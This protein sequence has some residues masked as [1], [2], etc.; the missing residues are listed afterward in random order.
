[1]DARARVLAAEAAAAL[2]DLAG[3]FDLVFLDPPYAD[4][5]E[6]TAPALVPGAAERLA[7]DGVLVLRLERTVRA[8]AL[9]GLALVRDRTYGR[10]R[11]CL[12]E[13]A[14]D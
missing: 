8:P 14:A 2:A 6:E 9:P 1:V 12:Y 11:V 5:R 7:P 10:S 13:A 3:A 4:A